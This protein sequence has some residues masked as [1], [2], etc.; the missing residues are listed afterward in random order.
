MYS[1][2][3]LTSNAILAKH[4]KSLID[5][6]QNKPAGYKRYHSFLYQ[7]KSWT[8]ARKVV[9]KVEM[10]ER[11]LNIRFIST[12]MSRAKAKH[13]Y[14]EIYC[15]RGNDEL[16]IKDHKTYTKSDR[17]SCHRFF[18]NQFRL[19]LHSAAYVLLHTYRSELLRGTSMAT[20]TFDSIRVKLLKVGARVIELKTKIKVHL[21]TACPY[22][23]IFAK[24][25]KM[26]ES[27]RGQSPPIQL[28]QKC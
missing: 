19:F 13:L 21:P 24:S 4:V 10:T 12:D 20:A 5:Q 7:A 3:G 25:L 16:Y 26:L 18:A 23:D 8:V 6:V 22:Q 9:A 15:A 14:E 1:V 17:T 27:L 28:V 2:A 11:G